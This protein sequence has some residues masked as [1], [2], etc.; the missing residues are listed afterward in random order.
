MKAATSLAFAPQTAVLQVQV[1]GISK[2]VGVSRRVEYGTLAKPPPRIVHVHVMWTPPRNCS[3]T[4]N[5]SL[6]ANVQFLKVY[7]LGVDL[8]T[9]PFMCAPV[10]RVVP[11]NYGSTQHA[12]LGVTTLT[13]HVVI[14]FTAFSGQTALLRPIPGGLVVPRDEFD[15]VLTYGFVLASC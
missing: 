6:A 8:L 4:T 11:S 12:L 13:G 3:L 15:A 10:M 7:C 2:T 5:I 1:V 14:G 9:V